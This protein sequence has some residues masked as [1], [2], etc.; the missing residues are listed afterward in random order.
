MKNLWNFLR[1]NFNF[2]TFY[3]PSLL[4]FFSFLLISQS[5]KKE[6][7]SIGLDLQNNLLGAIYTDTITL[8]AYS[9]LEDTLNTT[10]IASHCLGFLKD[11]IFGTTT[12]GIY[13]QLKPEGNNINLGEAPQLDSVVLI[14]RYSGGF[15]GDTLNPFVIKVY[16]VEEEIAST[17]I[18]YQN[19]LLSHSS[20]NL[21][22]RHN[23]LLY[24]Q[25]R[26]KVKTDTLLE[27]HIRIRL[28]NLF[29]ERLIRNISEMTSETTFKNY[30]KGLYI[31][32]EPYQNNGSLV[33][34]LLPTA[35]SGIVFYYKNENA[36]NKKFSLIID[37]ET[38]M[39]FSSFE[40][41]YEIGDG[42]F[43]R[44]TLNNDTLLGKNILYVQPLGGVKTKIAFPF[45]K[46]F[47]DKNIVINKAELVITDIGNESSF[48]PAPLALNISGMVNGKL[49]F[50]PDYSQ[51]SPYWG[52]N[53]IETDKEYRFRIT[54]YI[55]E[56][57][58]RDNFEPFIYLVSSGASIN[59]NR[60]L[61]GGTQPFE[62]TQRLRLELYYTEY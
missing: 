47:R 38:E 27:P 10:N 19:N 34:I 8:N 3:C 5:C 42:L 50:L 31:C 35:L 40:H 25:P 32:A 11:D 26:T 7:S 61:L 48:F 58:S 57:I 49:V 17:N 59:P 13:T 54:R 4:L 28:N 39:R 52:G 53:Y 41:N 1:V 22:Y 14:L 20:V 43:V 33:N 45:I 12:A 60:L 29:G 51:N 24:P 9:I 62:L 44:Q 18:Y 2:R 16:E 15:Y 23:F 56:I 21:T 36:E 30:F 6:P 55:Q 37:R 46:K